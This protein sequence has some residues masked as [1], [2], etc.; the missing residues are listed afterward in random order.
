MSD[1]LGPKTFLPSLK[2]ICHIFLSLSRTEFPLRRTVHCLSRSDSVW[3]VLPKDPHAIFVVSHGLTTGK[4]DRTLPWSD[5]VWVYWTTLT[6]KYNL[7]IIVLGL[8]S[9]IWSISVSSLIESNGADYEDFFSAFI[10]SPKA[11]RLVYR[12]LVSLKSMNPEK[13]KQNGM[14]TV[15]LTTAVNLTVQ[16]VQAG[17]LLHQKHQ[18]YQ[19]SF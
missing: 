2:A 6:Y 16:S 14:Q 7:L 17:A 19:F 5:S 13:I 9:S 4:T 12:K 1:R 3:G 15:N 11:N 18:T 10:R 8:I